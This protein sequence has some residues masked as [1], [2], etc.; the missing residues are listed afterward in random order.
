MSKL[1]RGIAPRKYLLASAPGTVAG[2]VTWI[3]SGELPSFC[4]R[5]KNFLALPRLT[6]RTMLCPV[7]VELMMLPP[8][9]LFGLRDLLIRRFGCEMTPLPVSAIAWGLPAA[10]SLIIK[11]ALNEPIAGGTNSMPTV[12]VLPAEMTLPVQ[13]L[14]AMMKLVDPVLLITAFVIVKSAEPQLLM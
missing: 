7:P 10:S 12:Q 6:L 4:T 14:A 2:P 5:T 8:I 11:L 9:K 1:S 13:P 3:A